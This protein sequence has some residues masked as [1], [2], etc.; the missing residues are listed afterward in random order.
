MGQA[1]KRMLSPLDI[2]FASLL[3]SIR[4][5]IVRDVDELLWN[6]ARFTALISTCLVKID[7]K[8]PVEGESDI[9]NAGFGGPAETSEKAT[10]ERDEPSIEKIYT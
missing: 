9:G 5:S 10:I 3:G 7:E 8:V 4:A 6:V 2:K 1:S